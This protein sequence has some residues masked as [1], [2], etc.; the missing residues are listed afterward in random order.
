[1]LANKLFTQTKSYPFQ[2]SEHIGIVF[3][4]NYI[5]VGN[6]SVA[7]MLVTDVV[8]QMIWWQV[9][10]VGDRFN[11]LRNHQHNEKSRQHNDSTATI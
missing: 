1:M 11:K 10:D 8:D 2:N 3:W 9:L 6:N 5:V 4:Y 7:S